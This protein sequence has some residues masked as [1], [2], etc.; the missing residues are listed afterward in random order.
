MD[1]QHTRKKGMKGEVVLIKAKDS[2]EL[3]KYA[4]TLKGKL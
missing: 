3:L 1:R 2:V 4:G